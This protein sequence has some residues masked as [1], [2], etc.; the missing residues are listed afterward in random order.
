MTVAGYDKLPK[1]PEPLSTEQKKSVFEN[2]TNI[3]LWLRSR[4]HEI[5][6]EH[7]EMVLETRR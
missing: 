3:L 7:A 6:D 1:W 5:D 4:G 2:Q